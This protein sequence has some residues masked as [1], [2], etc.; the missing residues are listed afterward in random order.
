MASFVR[1]LDARTIAIGGAGYQLWTWVNIP[2]VGTIGD[3]FTFAYRRVSGDFSARV[4]VSGRQFAPGSLG[5]ELGIMARQD[6]SRNSR[7]SFITDRG[8]NL[9]DKAFLT[10]R[11][12]HGTSGWAKVENPLAQGEH[13]NTF[14]LDRCGSVF[15]AYV[16]SAEDDWIP[17]GSHEWKPEAPGSLLVGLAVTSDQGCDVN[18]ITF[19]DWRLDPMCESQFV[20]GDANRDGRIDLTDAVVILDFL[21]LGNTSMLDCQKSADAD[22]NAVVNVSDGIYLLGFQ[23]LGGP[24]PPPP[25]PD[26]GLDTA[27]PDGLSCAFSECL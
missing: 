3:Q 11:E 4:T 10:Y 14:R 24:P 25:F 2:S 18:T 6:C 19:E 21:F 12:A 23:F 27:T 7:F 26:C 22:D 16:L 17:I 5:G 15:S 8:A 20:R 1:R 13:P 9:G